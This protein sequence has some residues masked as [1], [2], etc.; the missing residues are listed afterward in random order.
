[1]S[2]QAPG[3]EDPVHREGRR[4]RHAASGPNPRAW[5]G[6]GP[7]PAT[8]D[9]VTA[10]PGAEGRAGDAEPDEISDDPSGVEGGSHGASGGGASTPG[11]P[12]TA[13]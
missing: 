6:Y 2:Q 9:R 12:D 10:R 13:R 7:N 1:M 4:G 5:D 11:H 3:G 8:P